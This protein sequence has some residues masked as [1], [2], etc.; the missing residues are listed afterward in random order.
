[1]IE[2]S[3][4]QKISLLAD[5]IKKAE[6]IP[7]SRKLE[8]KATDLAIAIDELQLHNI[9][10][11]QLSDA[12]DKA[13]YL[14]VHWE[15]RAEF[16][17][18]LY[19]NWK[20]ILLGMK[21]LDCNL[22]EDINANFEETLRISPSNPTIFQTNDFFEEIDCIA[23]I[24][25][26][27][28]KKTICVVTPDKVFPTLLKARFGNTILVV[29]PRNFRESNTD[30]VIL[31][32]MIESIWNYGCQG[33]YW[34]HDSIRKSLGLR[35]SRDEQ[36]FARCVFQYSIYKKETF[37]TFPSKI[38]G[39]N[40]QSSK[41]LHEYMITHKCD[42]IQWTSRTPLNKSLR[43]FKE[44]QFQVPHKISTKDV[45]LLMNDPCDFYISKCLNLH[46]VA[47]NEESRALRGL[48]KILLHGFLSNEQNISE[49]ALI[50]I[51]NI[52]FYKY[53]HCKNIYSWLQKNCSFLQEQQHLKGMVY[54]YE[55]Q[56]TKLYS[57]I[58]LI[59]GSKMLF[60]RIFQ[61]K[62]RAN[63]IVNGKSCAPMISCLIA[64]KSACININELQIWDM[65]G[66]GE[67]PIDITHIEIGDEILDFFEKK[68]KETLSDC[69]VN[70]R[71][72][73][74]R[75]GHFKRV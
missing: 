28:R 50:D 59:M 9:S 66:L 7:N 74:E 56:G 71:S 32:N 31:S 18:I 13:N 44:I 27:N 33:S 4:N 63:D 38:G 16:L 73:S 19:S 12:I 35:T 65:H 30:V 40:A 70:T 75:Y 8:E 3:K 17:K 6:L 61:T 60:F 51:S 21:L 45:E 69:V 62:I 23:D 68:L 47:Y 15:K 57:E 55:F 25:E 67:E 53:H 58:D 52:D 2:I 14:A 64:K 54:E 5:F 26:K 22:F 37:I 36:E 43:D 72:I 41:I 49:T 24:K 11:G 48:Y 46:P 20:N 39:A 34:L 1:V 42:P 29:H 10:V